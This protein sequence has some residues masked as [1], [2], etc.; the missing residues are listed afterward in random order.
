MQQTVLFKAPGRS[1][2]SPLVILTGHN[3]TA[4][5]STNHFR[6]AGKMVFRTL[7]S[8]KATIA[9]AAIG[10]AAIWCHNIAIADAVEA[11]RAVATDC[12][13]MLPWGIVWAIRSTL[14][15]EGGEK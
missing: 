1:S 13:L 11:S 4:K 10:A 14:S 5:C 15:K 7:F 3:L 9:V 6:E 12:L 8:T 2:R